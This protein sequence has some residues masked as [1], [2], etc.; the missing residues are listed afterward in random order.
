MGLF[1][2][3]QEK[4]QNREQLKDIENRAKNHEYISDD[5]R[6]LYDRLHRTTLEEVVIKNDINEL[7]K[8]FDQKLPISS[9]QRA[10]FND[11]NKNSLDKLAW[12]RVSKEE[13]KL[14]KR[15]QKEKWVEIERNNIYIYR[16]EHIFFFNNNGII[17]FSDIIDFDVEAEV[18]TTSKT[19][20]KTKQKF[21]VGGALAGAAFGGGLG[22]VIGSKG[23]KGTYSSQTT[24]KQNVISYLVKIETY[25]HGAL[26]F[27][28]SAK[29]RNIADNLVLNL[30]IAL[31]EKSSLEEEKELFKKG[32]LEELYGVRK[33]HYELGYLEQLGEMSLENNYSL[34]KM[35][36]D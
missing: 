28:F 15:I 13:I 6:N 3:L 10:F 22:A 9:E 23:R 17:F 30:K 32:T 12:D 7:K 29:D 14:F 11:N 19:D 4:F 33:Q 24:S 25:N 35:I 27:K 20:G 5:E 26:Y 18:E 21:S 1:D 34:K 2:K 31:N 36:G 8:R 16:P